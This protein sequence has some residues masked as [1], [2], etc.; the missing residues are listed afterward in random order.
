MS[1]RKDSRDDAQL[2]PVARKYL[3]TLAELVDRLTIVQLKAIF[4]PEHRD[5]YLKEL[6]MIEHDIDA[7]LAEKHER[8]GYRIGARAIHAI[9]MIMLTN[10][11][12]WENESRARH[13]DNDQDRLL[14]L[15]HSING[16]RNSAKNALSRDVGERVDLKVDCFAESL[17]REFGNW[18]VFG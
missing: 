15:T 9:A 10:R 8:D 6:A 7:I 16:V 11:Y 17:V 4:I 12:I 18:N 3:P 5:E 2:R 13:G 1:D 14:K